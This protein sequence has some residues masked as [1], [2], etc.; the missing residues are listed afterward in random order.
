M[1]TEA[2]GTTRKNTMD[3][4]G[5]A[6]CAPESARLSLIEKLTHLLRERTSRLN[7]I[8]IVVSCPPLNA[9]I[10]AETG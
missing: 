3:H 10:N 9:Q 6:L 1:A 2:H 7:V 8:R 4:P 5:G